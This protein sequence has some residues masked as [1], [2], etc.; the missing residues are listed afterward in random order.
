VVCTARAAR[1][2]VG[3]WRVERAVER[4]VWV[5]VVGDRAREGAESANGREL[6]LTV[7]R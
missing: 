4:W 1:I 2:L 7:L 6:M 5:T 3:W